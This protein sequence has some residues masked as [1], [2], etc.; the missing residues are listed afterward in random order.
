M[1]P[2]QEGR[3]PWGCSE[4]WE[5]VCWLST[6]KAIS[7]TAATAVE[8]NI[9][10]KCLQKETPHG[11]PQ[12]SA[13]P[14]LSR[15]SYGPLS[16]QIQHGT[17]EIQETSQSRSRGR[18]RREENPRAVKPYSTEPNLPSGSGC[19]NFTRTVISLSLSP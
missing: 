5:W 4:Q 17:F 6:A 11:H 15:A 9:Y 13:Q 2:Q 18:T 14:W 7:L 19:P 12:C 16:P 10:W 3:P 1:F 8:I